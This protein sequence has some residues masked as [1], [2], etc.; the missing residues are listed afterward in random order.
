M[1]CVWP[2]NA[3]TSAAQDTWQAQP[4]PA[5]PLP[6]EWSEK[7]LAALP[8]CSHR[9]ATSP[10]VASPCPDPHSYWLRL[11]Q[12][13]LQAPAPH[14]RDSPTSCPACLQSR[15]T[16]AGVGSGLLFLQQHHALQAGA[17]RGR[18][19]LGCR[20]RGQPA[21]PGKASLLQVGAEAGGFG[22]RV[23]EEDAGWGQLVLPRG[24]TQPCLKTGG[25]APV[26]LAAPAKDAASARRTWGR[27]WSAWSRF[28]CP[29]PNMV[30]SR[31]RNC[32]SL[33]PMPVEAQSETMIVSHYRHLNLNNECFCRALVD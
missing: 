3:F 20:P 26:C 17:W 2:G 13:A 7:L 1:V 31:K 19:Q 18:R 4:H 16:S 32:K 10:A 12:G 8:P 27:E 6:S 25:R 11:W 21:V 29:Y 14:G 28:E 24:K 23:R 5:S 9:G 30:R 15:C 33:W 22:D